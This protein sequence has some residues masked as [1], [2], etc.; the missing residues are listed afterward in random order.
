MRIHRLNLLWLAVLSFLLLS[1]CGGGGG[2]SGSGGT[3]QNAAATPT[4][5]QMAT[6]QLNF[7]LTPREVPGDIQEFRIV[8]LGVAGQTLW[9][10]VTFPRQARILLENVPTS[11]VT[12]RIEYLR[13]G[14]VVGMATLSVHLTGGEMT[15][16]D[17]PPYQDVSLVVDELRVTPGQ[18][19][20]AAGLALQ[21]RAE[22]Y[23]NDRS[24]QDVTGAAQWRSDA[25][26]VATVNEGGRV[27]THRAG[28]ATIQ[29]RLGDH[30]G[31]CH[32]V[33]TEAVPVGLRLDPQQTSLPRGTSATLQAFLELSDGSSR[34][35]TAVVWQ[36]LAPAIASV[37]NGEVRGLEV[38][39]AAVTAQYGDFI[40]QAMVTVTSAQLV[41]VA[42]RPQLESL[43]LD[44][45]QVFTLEGTFTDQSLQ[46][47]GQV[48]WTGD[49]DTVVSLMNDGTA[50]ARSLG[51]ARITAEHVPSGM[52]AWLDVSVVEVVRAPSNLTAQPMAPTRIELLW[53]DNSDDEDRFLI[54]RSADGNV[55]T[56]VAMVGADTNRYLDRGLAPGTPYFYRVRA[57]GALGYSL[58][59]D[60]A[61]GSTPAVPAA[62]WPTL[63]AGPTHTFFNPTEWG[64]PPTGG[65]AW[66]RPLTLAALRPAVSAD[67]RVFVTTSDYRGDFRA[68]ALDPDNGNVLW[69]R[70][71][72]S[73]IYSLGQ[74]SVSD[75]K[76]FV[77]QCDHSVNSYLWCM[78]AATGTH[79]WNSPVAAQWN[80]YW[81][82]T[83]VGDKVYVNA[84]YYGGM[85]GFNATT[86]AELFFYRLEQYDEWSPSFYQGV[87]YSFV[88]G[89]LRAHDPQTGALLNTYTVPYE[90]NGWSTNSVP[91]FAEGD[92]FAIASPTLQRV[93]LTPEGTSWSSSGFT[94][95]YSP[96]YA[97]GML[98]AGAVGSVHAL[99]PADGSFEWSFPFE[100]R[101]PP[102]VA[103]GHLYLASATEVVAVNLA[104]HQQVWSTTPGGW[105]SVADGLLLVAGS[106]GTMRA[107]QL[108]RN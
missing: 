14:A 98:Y 22:A 74:P 7:N 5:N 41:S 61:T 10:P 93:A 48:N 3:S 76:L 96:A 47:L 87:L 99:N 30:Q 19:S 33:V 17:D 88:Q 97:D 78:D 29:A 1:G 79:L 60:P 75:G 53:A 21:L 62:P 106:D 65:P 63:G 11:V 80:R 39:G 72:D 73:D 84:G 92:A 90:W 23:F 13:N 15:V 55:F 77:M 37:D 85:Y 35:V 31:T 89:N 32:I 58:Y 2:E 9:G 36:S 57:Q 38:G 50:T 103:G 64:W 91:A 105:L 108:D 20:L 4:V 18:D 107:Y 25:P 43:A 86:G 100:V 24:S 68:L 71:F 26:E 83:V 6:V 49:P 16:V 28:Q 42:I 101:Y 66:T 67:G 27:E 54:E 81:A 104:T 102:V 44:S 46:T 45:Q 12:L 59:C 95:R 34:Q 40:A 8:G 82:P 52:S 51:T 70:V 94:Y 56:Q 69:E